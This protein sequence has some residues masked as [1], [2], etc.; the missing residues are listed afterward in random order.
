MSLLLPICP[1]EAERSNLSAVL[2]LKRRS[3]GAIIYVKATS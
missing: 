2:A 3:Q 1:E